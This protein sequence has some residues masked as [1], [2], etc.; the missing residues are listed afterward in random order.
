M[1]RIAVFAIALSITAMACAQDKLADIPISELGK[2]YQLVGKLHLP[3][4]QTTTIQ[5]FI[6]EGPSKGT[7]DGPN[8]RV[9]RIDGRS[10]Q[11]D[12]QI[13]V[14]PFF[15]KFGQTL[16]NGTEI[17]QLEIGA[18]YELEGYETGGYI[19]SPKDA[20]NRTKLAI[21]SGPL[22]FRQWFDIYKTK[23]IELIKDT[24]SDF[25]G[26]EALLE[27]TAKSEKNH[28]YIEA[29]GWKLLVN[30]KASWPAAVE[31]KTIEGFGKIKKSTLEKQF[32]LEAGKTRLVNLEDQLGKKVE[33]RGRAWSDNDNWWFD[34]RGHDIFIDNLEKVPGWNSDLRGEPVEFTGTLEEAMLPDLLEI[35]RTGTPRLIKQFIVR[36][37]K[38]TKIDKLLSPERVSRDDE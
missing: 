35:R 37:A 38:C 3:L 6:V 29:P 14:R 27:G 9:K 18:F 4:G 1:S 17:P 16:Y 26:R 31:G 28:A 30:D 23:K 36:N 22:Y 12:I 7:E 15:G 24:P 8:I 19:G 10:T 2:K 33:L 13:V 34:Y 21:Q 25:V 5:G 32:D 11:E 20:Y